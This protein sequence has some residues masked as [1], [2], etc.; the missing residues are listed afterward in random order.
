LK[1]ASGRVSSEEDDW[2]SYNEIGHVYSDKKRYESIPITNLSTSSG[3][4][5]EIVYNRS[6]KIINLAALKARHNKPFHRGCE[7]NDFNGSSFY[8]ST[9]KYGFNRIWFL[10]KKYPQE[11]LI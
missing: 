11:I 4:K 10:F 7:I 3:L 8:P 6:V 9:I 1:T 2:V 5:H